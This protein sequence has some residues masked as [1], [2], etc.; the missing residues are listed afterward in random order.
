MPIF[1]FECDNCKNQIEKL[2]S[3]TESEKLKKKCPKCNKGYLKKLY[4]S[5]FNFSL[6]GK[7]FKNMGEY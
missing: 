1:E 7:W 5:S 4:C 6:K 2:I 3:Y